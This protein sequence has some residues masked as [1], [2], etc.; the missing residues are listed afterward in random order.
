[1]ALVVKQFEIRT[2]KAPL[3]LGPGQY[4]D[5]ND[6]LVSTAPARKSRHDSLSEA[7]SEA[8][9]LGEAAYVYDLFNGRTVATIENDSVTVFRQLVW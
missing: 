1:M 9:L 6:S 5:I 7:V 4:E 3:R 8:R 2:H